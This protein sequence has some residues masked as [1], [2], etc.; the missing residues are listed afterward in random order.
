MLIFYKLLLLQ[1]IAHLFADFMFQ[2]QVW[3][4]SKRTKFISRH[5]FYHA[6]VV[7][8]CASIL[9]FKDNFVVFA[10]ILAIS[11]LAV[12]ILKSYLSLKSKINESTLFFAD[13]FIHLIIIC[14]IIYWYWSIG[15]VKSYSEISLKS[16]AVIAAF[17]LCAKPSN[18]LVK[19]IFLGLQIDIPKKDD[20]ISDKNTE[21]PNAG[22]LIGLM[23]RFLVLALIL[24]GQ[25]SAVGLIIAAKSILR[26]KDNQKNEYVLIGTLLSFGIAILLGILIREIFPIY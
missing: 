15:S 1:F 17:T 22:K 3:A 9:A 2:P 10:G 16:I 24:V 4:I 11:H 14:S 6:A 26:F 7:F 19:N 13:Q 5:H 23:E 25:Y 18:I 20:S 21:L 8:A 12:D